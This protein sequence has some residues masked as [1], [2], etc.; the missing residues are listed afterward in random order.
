RYRDIVKKEAGLRNALEETTARCEQVSAL[1]ECKE[2]AV[3]SHNVALEDMRAKLRVISASVPDS[4]STAK[5]SAADMVK[6][7]LKTVISPQVVIAA[8]S[9]VS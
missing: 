5:V 4:I 6:N 7:V 9:K 8:E 1:L 2:N 3:S